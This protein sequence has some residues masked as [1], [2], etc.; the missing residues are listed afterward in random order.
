MKSFIK[1]VRV[2]TDI[3]CLTVLSLEL[4]DQIS[5]IRQRKAATM[6]AAQ[7]TKEE[8]SNE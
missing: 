5:K 7:A 8:I 3:V 6:A 1:C 4:K 2:L